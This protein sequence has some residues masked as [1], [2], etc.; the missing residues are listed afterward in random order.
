MP[1][2]TIS[3]SRRQLAT[4]SR[5]LAC[6]PEG[7]SWC[8]RSINPAA[9]NIPLVAKKRKQ[10]KNE[11]ASYLDGLAIWGSGAVRPFGKRFSQ[12]LMPAEV[13]TIAIV[14]QKRMSA[15]LRLSQA[16]ILNT[17]LLLVAPPQ[18]AYPEVQR[19]QTGAWYCNRH[20]RSSG[21]SFRELK[22]RAYADIRGQYQQ[23]K[24]PAINR[25][26]D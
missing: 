10:V 25:G 23:R 4:P 9:F 5:R 2:A 3:S 19:S 8:F 7:R 12:M 17:A 21:E 16:R 24:T 11:A 26:R 6:S 14:I 22:V 13:S 1:R 18:P 15:I 20:G